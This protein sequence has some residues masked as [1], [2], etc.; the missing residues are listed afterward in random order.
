MP[1][2]VVA[3]ASQCQLGEGPLW[4]PGL[5]RLY[6]VD[7][8]GK[9]VHWYE[10]RTQT[11]QRVLFP[12][13]VTALGLRRAGGLVVATE[14]GF[15]VWPESTSPRLNFLAHPEA[16]R[17]QA[18]FNDGRVDPAGGFI[19]GTME[20]SEP[21]SPSS[22]LYRLDAQGRVTTLATH[23]TLSN[24]VGFSPDRATMYHTDTGALTIWA[25]DFDART[26]AIANRRVFVRTDE[27][28]GFPDGLTV[29]AEGGVWSARWDAGIVVRY[30][31]AGRRDLALRLPVSRPSSCTFGGEDLGDLYIT[32]AQPDEPTREPE[33]GNVFRVRTGFFGL[34]EPEWQG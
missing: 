29:D 32:T 5:G 2:P 20:R 33:A 12:L 4:H 14:N 21:R 17:P 13:M 16:D 6:W 8:I 15:A 10:P 30:T 27:E 7:I 26:G 1:T 22:A 24:G 9:A 19:A 25:Y 23:I 3:V 31:A 34:P 18:R 11:D 28:P